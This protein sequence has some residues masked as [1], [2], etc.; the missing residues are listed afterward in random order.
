ML[1]E[2]DCLKTQPIVESLEKLFNPKN[3]LLPNGKSIDVE[4]SEWAQKELNICVEHFNKN[5]KIWNLV[6]MQ[7]QYATFVK[8]VADN[9]QFHGAWKHAD[10][11]D[12]GKWHP[13]RIIEHLKNPATEYTLIRKYHLKHLFSTEMATDIPQ[14]SRL[15]G[16]AGLILPSS[17]CT[18]RLVKQ[19]KYDSPIS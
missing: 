11:I 6:Q 8:R 12:K 7:L 17:C 14:L 2:W 13:L 16:I 4:H 10:G 18:E 5:P 19:H 15:A 3:F 9:S 1:N